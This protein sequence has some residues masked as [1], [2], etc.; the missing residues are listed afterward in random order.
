GHPF[1]SL[2]D[3]EMP[4]QTGFIHTIY[5]RLTVSFKMGSP[6]KTVGVINAD[7]STG[8]AGWLDRKPDLMPMRMT[9]VRGS[10][11]S[12]HVFNVETVRQKQLL[13]SL[14]FTALTNAVDMEGDLPEEMTAQMEARIEMEGRD[15]LVMTDTFSGGS[16]S[17]G[18]APQALYGPVASVVS[19][20][21]SNPY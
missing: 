17:G 13:P 14:V 19:Q 4:L 1:M 10:Q 5:P 18:R 3:C 21:V 6:L 16:Y 7:V 20:L 2:G 15:P 9:L 12:P 8:I 11:G